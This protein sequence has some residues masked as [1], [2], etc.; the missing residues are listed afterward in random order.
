MTME[1]A[2]L[3]ETHRML[4]GPGIRDELREWH[5]GVGCDPSCVDEIVDAE[6]EQRKRDFLQARAEYEL[7]MCSEVMD[8]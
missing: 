2:R 4:C 7:A 5:L 6:M 1:L 8:T 3:I